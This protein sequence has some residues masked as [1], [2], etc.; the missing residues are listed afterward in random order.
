M[1]SFARAAVALALGLGVVAGATAADTYPN[2]PI[3]FYVGFPPGGSTD[4]AARI[5]APALA[6]K[7][8]QPIIIDNQ[9]G[10]GGVIGIDVI[11]KAKPDGYS[12]GF[13]VSGALTANVTLMPSLPYDP[14]KDITAVSQVVDNPLVLA[15]N[16]DSGITTLQGFIAQGKAKPGSISYGT[17][18]PGTAMNLAG[19][20]L[21]QRTGIAMEHVPYK[22]SSPA[23]V[24]L[25]ANH[26]EAVVVDLASAKPHIDSGRLKALAV[27]SAQRTPLAPDVP[28]MAEGGVADYAV[29]SWFSL[30]MPA[31]VPQPILD[32]VHGALVAVLADPKVA[33]QLARSGLTP[34]SS[35]PQELAARINR[36]ITL[37]ADL[38][39]AA[40][41]TR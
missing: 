11:S 4:T 17:P 30:I 33:E 41:I 34:K 15:V 35:T 19:E 3:Q 9:A 1:T 36:E 27:T 20:L 28:T 23:V 37:Y 2:R 7:L 12:M 32:K 18:G 26:I 29:E 24:D 22:G 14:R 8:G 21:N 40:N 6:Q 39:K 13:G 5:I 38:I 10:A 31:G 16:T 25:M